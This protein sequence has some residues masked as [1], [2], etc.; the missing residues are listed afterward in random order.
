MTLA[1]AHLNSEST[2]I[3]APPASYGDGEKARGAIFT[4]HSVVEFMLDLI[5]YTPE[6]SLYTKSLLEPSFGSGRFILAAV[7]RPTVKG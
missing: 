5:G 6:M 7:D 2:Q 4:R 1:P 3:A